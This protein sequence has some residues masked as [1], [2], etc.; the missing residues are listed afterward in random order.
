MRTKHEFFDVCRSPELACEVTLQPITRYTGLLDAAIIFSDILV[1][2][3][4]L[5]MTVTMEAGQGP[6][7]PEPLVDPSHLER[8][9]THVDVQKQLGYVFEAITLTRHRLA[10][11][12]PLIGFSGAPW[13]LMA[14]MVEGGGS[15]T[16]A[17]A[18]T[19]LFR[20]PKES[21][22]LLQRIGV[23]CIDYLMGQILAGAQVRCMRYFGCTESH[24]VYPQA[25]STFRL[26]GGGI[27][28]QPVSRIR[29]AILRP[30]IVRCARTF[31]ADPNA[32]GTVYTIRQRSKLRH[33]RTL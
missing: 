13:T 19:W 30:N 23:V 24:M 33:R 5:G 9:P 10:G 7:L 32:G 26:V 18:K 25:G 22:E 4:A 20:Y 17:K 27:I 15:K 21:R 12:V 8:L 28:T 16:F 6:V 1:I 14:Y 11:E 31:G 29:P 3:Q 2:P